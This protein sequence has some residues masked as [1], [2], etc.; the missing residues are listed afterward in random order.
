[1]VS[2]SWL[3]YLTTINISKGRL[4][5][6][7]KKHR[8]FHAVLYTLPLLFKIRKNHEMRST[9]KEDKWKNFKREELDKHV[10]VTTPNYA[11][12]FGSFGIWR[13]IYTL[14]SSKVTIIFIFMN[15]IF[16]YLRNSWKAWEI[17]NILQ[18][19]RIQKTQTLQTTS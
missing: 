4:V 11:F 2:F 19:P 6:F 1:M 13:S 10:V 8:Q 14:K 16:M 3:F 17:A 15:T 12:F 5:Q 18:S 9:F 7:H